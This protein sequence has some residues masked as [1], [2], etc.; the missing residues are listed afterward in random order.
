MNQI[1]YAIVLFGCSKLKSKL[2]SA[3]LHFTLMP[4]LLCNGTLRESFCNV[5][6]FNGILRC[7]SKKGILRHNS[8]LKCRE[9]TELAESQ[10]ILYIWRCILYFPR[11]FHQKMNS[12]DRLY[13]LN[14]LAS[15]QT[16]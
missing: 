14:F 11:P 7:K 2:C 6:I 1:Y 8:Y 10:C 9:K 16:I 3:H 13:L 15:L 5:V 4:S 12:A